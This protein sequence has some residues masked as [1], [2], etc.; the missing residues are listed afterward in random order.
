MPREYR[1]PLSLPAL[2]IF[3]LLAGSAWAQTAS[4]PDSGSSELRQILNRLE[5]LE[6]QNT[7]LASEVR[8]LRKELASTRGTA[9][10]EPVPEPETQPPAPSIPSPEERLTIQE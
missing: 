6:Q 9:V 5:R 8:E 3:L 2:Q 1:K 4:P 7:A 10:P